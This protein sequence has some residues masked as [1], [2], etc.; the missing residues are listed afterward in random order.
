MKAIILS[1][2]CL[3]IFP[4]LTFSQTMIIHKKDGTVHSII[5][6]DI[7]SISFSQGGGGM[8][9]P[10]IPTVEY[11]GQIYNTVQIGNQCWFKENLNVGI[12]ITNTTV[13]NN[14]TDNG[15]IE[16]YCYD[17]NVSN[18][19]IFGGLY[20]WPEAMQYS[21]TEGT[22]DIC[23][24]GW[25]IPTNSEFEILANTVG[26]SGNALKALGQGEGNGEGTNSSGFSALFA[27]LRLFS[28][29]SLDFNSLGEFTYFWTSTEV[30]S[31]EAYNRVLVS[32]GRDFNFEAR[33]KYHGFSVRCLKD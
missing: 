25:H 9:C 2:L 16:K 22:Q 6:N 7:D 8:P 5:L 20:Q 33:N 3:I 10:G 17:N 19:S 31:S 23:P 26:G 11:E 13:I 4:V 14:Q 18:C 1:M 12:K 30:S 24:P 28:V 21:T 32:W 15:V 27:G 29:S